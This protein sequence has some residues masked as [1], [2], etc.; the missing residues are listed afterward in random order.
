[1]G[2]TRSGSWVDNVQTGPGVEIW[3]DRHLCE[4]DMFVFNGQFVDGRRDGHG[5]FTWPDGSIYTGAWRRNK[6]NGAGWQITNRN[7]RRAVEYKGF[8]QDSMFHG[9]GNSKWSDGREYSGGHRE[10][11]KHGFGVLKWSDGC[12]YVGYFEKGQQHGQG[13]RTKDGEELLG[14]W[15]HGRLDSD[16]E[17][18]DAVEHSD[19]LMGSVVRE[20]SEETS[21]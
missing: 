9:M 17:L 20:N 14:N 11:L 18:S 5:V 2:I 19:G 12:E 1:M 8:W 13:K 7:L 16:D 3:S 10:D 15:V 6:A 4:S 21:A